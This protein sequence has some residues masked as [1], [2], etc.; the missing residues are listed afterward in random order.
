MKLTDAHKQA[1][2]R[3]KN[4]GDVFAY[5]TA[6]LL[7]EVE[8]HHPEMIV[9]ERAKSDIP[10]DQQQPY[11]GAILTAAGIRAIQEAA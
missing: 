3:V 4:G 1:M 2:A 11:F 10:G 8:R 6:Q 5:E 7:R 9:I